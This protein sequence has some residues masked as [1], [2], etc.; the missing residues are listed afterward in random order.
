MSTDFF[1]V[2]PDCLN[3]KR[4]FHPRDNEP[5]AH[6]WFGGIEKGT[7]VDF[8]SSFVKETDNLLLVSESGETMLV[9][10]LKDEI[11]KGKKA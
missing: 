1:E 6:R 11:G 3:D 7:Q 2:C 4:H 10:D 9:A 8:F 5:V